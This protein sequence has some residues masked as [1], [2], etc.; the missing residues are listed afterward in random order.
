MIGAP[1]MAF[2]R[3]NNFSFWLLP[4]AL[5]LLVLSAFTDQGVGTG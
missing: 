2:A 5:F 3:V 1:D 4:A